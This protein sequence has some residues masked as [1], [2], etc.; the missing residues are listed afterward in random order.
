MD[1]LSQH[2]CLDARITMPNG[3]S[4]SLPS[5]D[6]YLLSAPAADLIDFIC[7]QP[8]HRSRGHFLDWLQASV[9]ESR[10]WRSDYLSGKERLYL[11]VNTQALQFLLGSRRPEVHLALWDAGYYQHETPAGNL[12]HAASL[13]EQLGFAA[14]YHYGYDDGRSYFRMLDSNAAKIIVDSEE[15]EISCDSLIKKMIAR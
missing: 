6:D 2:P 13:Y 3:S 1:E 9:S 15:I 10:Q 5:F 14:Q 8:P 4:Y 7:G 12:A 11:V